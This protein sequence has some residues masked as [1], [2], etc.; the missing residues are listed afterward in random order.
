M[1]DPTFIEAARVLAQRVL[2]EVNG[3]PAA[4]VRAV[5]RRVLAREPDQRE[6]ETM[7]AVL[8]A[9]AAGYRADPDRAARLL[10]VGE[11]P[12]DP[13][14]DPCDVA[15]LAGVAAVIFNLDETLTRE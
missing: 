10:S 5:F 13:A 11:F 2:V 9:A 7:Q 4:R 12:S 3:D 6:R 14:L 1:N 8:D 15:A